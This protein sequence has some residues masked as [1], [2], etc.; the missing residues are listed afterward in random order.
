MESRSAKSCFFAGIFSPRNIL[1]PENRIL[2]CRPG[3][4]MKPILEIKNISKKFRIRHESR[5]YLSVRDSLASLLKPRKFISE[6]FY[7]LN[8]VSFNVDAG[9]SV[10]IIGE[11][12]AG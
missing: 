9:E 5:P 11:N 2:F 3:I 1:L 10:G 8:D 7:A 4:D 12:G 6:D